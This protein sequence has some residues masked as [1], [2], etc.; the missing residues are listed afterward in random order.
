MNKPALPKLRLTPFIDGAFEEAGVGG[1]AL[2]D[3]A[4][5]EALA[6]VHAASQEQVLKAIAAARRAF[7]EGDWPRMPV[8][9]RGQVLRAI[10]D[11]ILAR[12]DDLALL[13]SVNGGK[14]IAG[15][16]REVAGAAKVFHYYAGAMDK[17]FGDKIGRAHV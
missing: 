4:T 14:P 17:F 1:D 10:A 12:S 9:E 16:R 13:E 8:F 3:P 2:L 11:G 6:S 15:A 7:D 5:G